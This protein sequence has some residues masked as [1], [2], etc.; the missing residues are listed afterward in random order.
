M[1]SAYHDELC[2]RCGQEAVDHFE[3]PELSESR[4]DTDETVG[5]EEAAECWVETCLRAQFISAGA[6]H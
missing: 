1:S 2:Q 3:R 6:L 4:R 5:K